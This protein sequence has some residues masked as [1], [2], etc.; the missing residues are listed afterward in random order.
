MKSNTSPK[1][2]LQQRSSISRREFIKQS[3]LLGSGLLLCGTTGI[4]NSCTR[5]TSFDTL[6]TNS[7][8]YTGDGSAPFVGDVGIISGHIAA[9]GKLAKKATK[10]IDADSLAVCP[11]F[12]D[13]HSH[14]DTNL[15]DCPAGDSR[16]YQGITTE[17]G[18]NC[19]GSP[20]PNNPYTSF[21]EFREALLQ[22][23]IGINY[24]TFAGQ[25][26]IRNAVVGPHDIP[27][28][29]TQIV[30]M[31][32]LTDKLLKE[33]CIG[34]SCGLE[35][36]PGAYAS[37]DEL[38]SLL[39]VVASH[40]KLFAIHMRN[41]DDNVEQALA[42]AIDLSRRSKVRLQI[43]H[44]K[45][46]NQANWHKG[47]ALLKQIEQA[48]TEGIDIAFDRY[49]YI[50][51]STNLSSFIP[52]ER[53]QGT[54]QELISLLKNPDSQS[55]LSAYAASRIE[56]LGGPRNVVISSCILP[57]NKTDYMGKNLEECAQTSGLNLW[58]FIRHLLIEEELETEMIAYAMT[59]DNVKL[60]LSH[61]L[62]MPAS[63]GSV[64]SPVGILSEGMPHPRSYG[65]FPRF[66]GKYCREEK[67]VDLPTAIHKITAL[68]ASRLGLK[69]RG[70][71]LP[72]YA[73]DIVLF[74]P[75]QIADLST[76]ENPH[77]FAKGIHHIWV[78][79]VHTI[80]DGHHN[81]ALAGQL[82]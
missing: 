69:D 24:C 38:V 32:Q 18:G 17:A 8:I 53:R 52:L 3:A 67:I 19:G 63:D 51:F 66:L 1:R 73:A 14:T 10:I 72:G 36:A 43:S 29:D 7:L 12:I 64:Y 34:L 62:G 25:G 80:A 44:L 57:R 42:Q 16:I 77:Q 4:L 11:G 71:L 60:F 22:K 82:V 79:G 13:I 5:N 26:D 81:G 78:N 39:T 75:S 47:P 55:E 49:P 23:G 35:Y 65:T 45:A 33:G 76:F 6:I 28:T 40:N 41:E 21:A 59:E 48:H 15:I 20:F 56:R 54:T 9:V 30:Q 27:A 50:A 74:D 70:L 46:Q 61:P 58:E 37:D 68:P 2:H 31:Q